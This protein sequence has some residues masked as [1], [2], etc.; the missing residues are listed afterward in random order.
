MPTVLVVDDEPHIRDVLRGYLTADGHRVLEAGTGE[1]ALATLARDT[2]DLVLL[3]IMLP[4]IDGL[5]TLRRVRTTSDV[6]VILVTAR[7]E[8]VDTLVGL[9]VGAD[10]YVT[11]PFSPREVAARVSAVLRR[12]RGPAPEADVIAHEGFVLDRARHE[13]S[14]DGTPVELSPLEFDLLA[15]LAAAPGRVYSRA[16][17]LRQ[18]W[19]QDWFGDERVVDVHVRSIRSRLGDDA[20]DPRFVATVRGVGYKFVGRPR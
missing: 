2:V 16:Q 20:N 11:K 8:E 3:D 17:L 18:V 15:A 13:V 6:F 19:G 5:E 1:E 4:G 14:V 7:A 9:A 10:D 12:D